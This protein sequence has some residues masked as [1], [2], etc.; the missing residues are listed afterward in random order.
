VP[1]VAQHVLKV[2]IVCTGCTVDVNGVRERFR[3]IFVEPG[4]THRIVAAF[5]TGTRETTVTGAAGEEREVAFEAPARGGTGEGGGEGGSGGG[6]SGEGGGGGGGGGGSGFGG[7]SGGGGSSDD[8]GGGGISP[9]FFIV[10]GGLTVV[11][12]GLSL[13]SGIDVLT[14][15]ANYDT[16]MTID[17]LEAGNAAETRSNIFFIATGGLAAVTV[18]LL[19]L[20]DFSGG[21]DDGEASGL[22]LDAAPLAEGGAFATL[23]S[24]F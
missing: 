7:G 9:I 17:Q 8:G 3:T 1:E 5:A 4:E 15:K 13:W 18:V 23:T 6:G 22:R 2:R 12:G 20:T 11:A 10:A 21:D 14:Q 19:L 24:R 16:A